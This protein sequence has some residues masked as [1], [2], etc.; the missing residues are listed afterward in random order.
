[1]NKHTP[2]LVV[3]TIGVLIFSACTSKPQSTSLSGTSWKLVSYGPT[4]DQIP[5]AEG[6]DTQIDFSTDGKVSGTMG[7]NRFS[8]SYEQK[9]AQLT[10]GPLMATKMA[11][12]DLPMTQESV[13]FGVMVDTVKYELSG[14][15]LII[16]NEDATLKI[17]LEQ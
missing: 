3:F 6:I 15:Q 2:L 11:C 1:M 9:E 5:A 12:P 10:F 16:F 13:A 14:S 17:V 7:C 8:G 4:E